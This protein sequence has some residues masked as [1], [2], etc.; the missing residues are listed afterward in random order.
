[1]LSTAPSSHPVSKILLVSALVF[2]AAFHVRPAA[3]QASGSLTADAQKAAELDMYRAFLA[4][5]VKVGPPDEVALDKK[6]D[7]QADGDAMTLRNAYYD[8]PHGQQSTA[9]YDEESK[10]VK[11]IQANQPAY[12]A[13]MDAIAKQVDQELAGEASPQPAPAKRATTKPQGDMPRA[14]TI[15]DASASRVATTM[16]SVP[17]VPIALGTVFV[18]AIGGVGFFVVKRRKSRPAPT[19]VWPPVASKM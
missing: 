17:I 10:D 12:I 6:R 13:Q 16:E 5:R 19:S 15:P 1:M 18:A 11:A 9:F 8:G 4:N 14:V 2:T 7:L 3:A